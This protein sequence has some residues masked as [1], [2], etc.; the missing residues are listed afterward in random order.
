MNCLAC[1]T[2]LFCGER[3]GTD[4]CVP[5]SPVQLASACW[6]CA[7]LQ[8]SSTLGVPPGEGQNTSSEQH[9]A[10]WFFHHLCCVKSVIV[11][12]WHF[13]YKDWYWKLMHIDCS[14]DY[15]WVCLFE[16]MLV[17]KHRWEAWNQLCWAIFG[18]KMLKQEP[19]RCSPT[20]SLFSSFNLWSHAHHCAVAANFTLR[21]HY[22]TGSL[23]RWVIMWSG[24]LHVNCTF[25]VGWKSMMRAECCLMVVIVIRGLQNVHSLMLVVLAVIENMSKSQ[26]YRFYCSLATFVPICRGK[27]LTCTFRVKGSG[28]G[29][30]ECARCVFWTR[31]CFVWEWDD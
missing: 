7:G 20:Q 30:S 18:R 2:S 9:G 29:P 16:I 17:A 13:M 19:G 31:F 24:C 3:D 1:V 11:N 14:F 23:F 25:D 22:Y 26:R 5:C 15:D 12:L 6:R 28:E 8:P 4:I 10:S 27:W 21:L